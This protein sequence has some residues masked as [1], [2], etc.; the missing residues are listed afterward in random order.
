MPTL[1]RPLIDMTAG[2]LMS[3]DVVTI[4]RHMSLHA[5]AHLL[6]H[7]RIS[8]APV[9]DEQGRCVGMLTSSDL[10]RW[11]ENGERASRRLFHTAACMCTDWQ[12][13]EFSALPSDAV[14]RHMTTDLVTAQPS[15]HVAELARIMIDAHIHRILITD[16]QSRPAGIVT[17]TDILAAVARG[18]REDENSPNAGS[19]G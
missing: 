12:V 2:D 6:N 1:T 18:A 10:M 13:T 19:E 5:A 16:G 3:R 11:V 17:S 4:P 14:S 9:V 15:T 8:G 7:A